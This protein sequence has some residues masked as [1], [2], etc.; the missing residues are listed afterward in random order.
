MKKVI[1]FT[2]ICLV[3]IQFIRI[4]KTN[5]VTAKELEIKAPEHIMSVFKS[6]CYDC[7]SNEVKWPW[8]ANIA[9]FSWVISDHV[10]TGRAWLNFSTWENYT[11]EEKKK[12]LKGIYRTVY[13][14][15][16]LESYVMFHEE[17][18]LTREQRSM[19]R[20]WTGVRK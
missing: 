19:I 15:M 17:A 4:D 20:E 9:P 3:A 12:K 11:Q 1:F 16:P 5:E 13:A 6:S 18:N 2:I 10:K 7:H 8:Y 14:S